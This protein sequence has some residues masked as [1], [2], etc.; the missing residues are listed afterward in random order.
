MGSLPSVTG[1]TRWATKP[2]SAPSAW[3]S[4]LV[5]SR[6]RPK[7]KSWPTNTSRARSPITTCSTNSRAGCDE[8]A[9]S[10][11]CTITASRP[12][13][14]MSSRRRSREVST[15][16]ARRGEDARRVR[17]EGER[18]GGAAEGAGGVDHAAEE[19][20]VPA[21]DAV[22]IADREGRGRREARE[23]VVMG[24]QHGHWALRGGRYHRGAARREPEAARTGVGWVCRCRSCTRRLRKAAPPPGASEPDDVSFRM[25]STGCSVREQRCPTGP[26]R[27]TQSSAPYRLRRSCAVRCEPRVFGMSRQRVKS[28]RSSP[29]RSSS[30]SAA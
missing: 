20:L 29:S 6:L 26:R 17:V 15:G 23:A 2:S 11:R 3:S 22:E 8:R 19:V 7:W 18:D 25:I 24:D 5:P 1:S 4:S 28:S 10:K 14:A 27:P 21:V 30:Y 13:S 16:G 12:A 9:V